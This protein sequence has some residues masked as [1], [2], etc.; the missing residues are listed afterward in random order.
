MP[1]HC[2]V[3]WNGGGGGGKE[4]QTVIMITGVGW[5]GV[6]AFM[7][8]FTATTIFIDQMWSLLVVKTS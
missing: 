7:I 2:P 6:V 5:G 4:G 8:E 1:S 3:L